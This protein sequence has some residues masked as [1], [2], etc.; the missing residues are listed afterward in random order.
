MFKE[1]LLGLATTTGAWIL[2]P[3]SHNGVYEMVGSAVKDH[4]DATGSTS[5][6]DI[7]LLGIAAWE[8]VAER[9]RLVD[10]SE[11]GCFPAEYQI[12]KILGLTASRP[13]LQQD[14]QVLDPNHSHFI[15][16]DDR[17]SGVSEEESSWR[18]TFEAFL[19][20]HVISG[21]ED[22]DE[23]HIPMVTLLVNGDK[24]S[25]KRC[26]ESVKRHIPLV[27]VAGSGDA[28]EIVAVINAL[29][30]GENGSWGPEKD[31][32][33]EIYERAMEEDCP[34]DCL[35]AME[36]IAANHKYISV[37][38]LQQLAT[39]SNEIGL[40]MAILSALYHPD[41]LDISKMKAQT[42]LAIAWARVD[43]A[44][45]ELF[46]IRSQ[47]YHALMEERGF[48]EEVAIEALLNNLPEFVE[49][50]IEQGLNLSFLVT[51]KNLET[52][53]KKTGC[54][55]RNNAVQ[56]PDCMH[57]VGEML[58]YVLGNTYPNIYKVDHEGVSMNAE[59][60]RGQIRFKDPVQHLFLWAVVFNK[61]ELTKILWRI[62]DD[63]VAGAVIGAALFRGMSRES[64]SRDRKDVSAAYLKNAQELENL[65]INILSSC[66][67]KDEQY[68]SDMLVREAPNWGHTT[69]LSMAYHGGL[70]DFMGQPACH[71]KLKDI[72]RGDIAMKIHAVWI[73]LVA[74]IPLLVPILAFEK[75]KD[76]E[77][78]V[79]DKRQSI[80]PTNAAMAKQ[81]NQ[82]DSLLK[83]TLCGFGKG[84]ISYP[85][86]IYKTLCA[87]I[88]KCVHYAIALLAF[89]TVFAFFIMTELRP[90]DSLGFNSTNNESM[91]SDYRPCC[92]AGNLSCLE[93][94]TYGYALHSLIDKLRQIVRKN[95]IS[96]VTDW[97][98]EI[99]MIRDMSA[100]AI[101][102]VSITM[103]FTVNGQ[104]FSWARWFYSFSF[105]L[106]F[107]R[108]TEVFYVVDSLGPN[109]TIMMKMMSELGFLIVVL[110]TIILVFGVV[111]QAIIFP[112]SVLNDVLIRNI[113]Y[114]PYYQMYGE[115]FLED[116]QTGFTSYLLGF[117][118][119]LTNI[120]L[121]NLLIAM[122]SH[123]FA[124]VQEK[125]ELLWKYNFFEAL[126]EHLDRPYIPILGSLLQPCLNLD[127]KPSSRQTSE[128]M[129]HLDSEHNSKI[130]KF[131][132]VCTEKYM[133]EEKKGNGD[134]IEHKSH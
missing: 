7:V 37:F 116:Y 68:T 83:V 93:I 13:S 129:I 120:L 26:A 112:E 80:Y 78:L 113:I 96:R 32:L 11:D 5:M 63:H 4:L 33:K 39:D 84:K 19:T 102:I 85:K 17:S 71:N 6:D 49:L 44:R 57:R 61:L 70:L 106:F 54:C 76:M 20:S 104:Y 132:K 125:A 99:A 69:V 81:L 41:D 75:K 51:R 14:T 62:C 56:E 131:V 98:R 22:D 79:M 89:L 29:S 114:K 23:V 97:S 101:L 38:D 55:P 36:V 15:M 134:E 121:L 109:F 90:I 64:E 111:T 128:F 48:L 87:P 10:N 73:L 40:D 122:F 3:G 1:G 117:Y 46:N 100:F 12:H 110:V 30:E 18:S 58:R 77:E 31:K 43:Y 88:V 24:E 21:T 25:L 27:T 42:R 66:W 105:V 124:K 115:L 119:I 127:C 107:V 103:R 34:Q 45:N 91:C 65:A 35:K 118:L 16:V 95:K 8:S 2:T 82:G 72:W 9:Q 92:I 53:Y 130:S 59:V 94:I 86:A 50:F 67:S 133:A 60:K 108:F 74:F 123:K 126:H 28:A 52:L 47:H